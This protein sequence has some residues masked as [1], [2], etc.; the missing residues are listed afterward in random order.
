METNPDPQD[1]NPF[2]YCGEYFDVETGTYYLRAR[3]YDPGIGRFTQQDTHWNTANSI[4][5]DNP[6]KTNE[7]ED[8]LGLKTYSYA[9]QITA[10]MQSGN[11]YVYGVSNPVAYVDQDGQIQFF[12]ETIGFCP[13]AALWKGPSGNEYI[14]YW[15]RQLLKILDYLQTGS[16]HAAFNEIETTQLW[17]EAYRVDDLVALRKVKICGHMRE[18]D[19]CDNEAFH[20]DTAKMIPFT[21][22]REV[23]QTTARQFLDDVLAQLPNALEEMIT[24]REIKCMLG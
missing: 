2:R 14:D 4:Y 24:L 8:K 23:I 1:E 21:Q 10:V 11:L 7:R 16:T 18:L 13:D 12:D 20:G 17:I 15:I 9:P 3:Y 5:G 22:F 19:F 6:Q